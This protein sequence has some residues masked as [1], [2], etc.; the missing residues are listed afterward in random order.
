MRDAWSV[1]LCVF[2]TLECASEQTARPGDAIPFLELFDKETDL[3]EWTRML[4]V[5]ERRGAHELLTL[6]SRARKSANARWRP[7]WTGIHHVCSQ[8]DLLILMPHHSRSVGAWKSPLKSRP[9]QPQLTGLKREAPLA[10]AVLPVQSRSSFNLK[11][12]CGT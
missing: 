7:R 4:G 8:G 3:A 10:S 11:L 2:F 12:G 6:W 5:V 9:P 1:Y